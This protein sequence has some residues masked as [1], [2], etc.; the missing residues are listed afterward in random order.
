VLPD[1]SLML[2]GPFMGHDSGELV[3]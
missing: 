2:I 1:V 3:C